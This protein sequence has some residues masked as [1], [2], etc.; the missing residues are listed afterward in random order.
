MPMRYRAKPR[1]PSPGKRFARRG[2]ARNIDARWPDREDDDEKPPSTA[3][4]A[5]DRS[6]RRNLRRAGNDEVE[7]G[8]G[9]DTVTGED[10]S[11]RID[12]D[13][14]YDAIYTGIGDNRVFGGQGTDLVVGGPGNDYARG[15]DGP[16]SL[17]GLEGNDD[18]DGEDRR[19]RHERRRLQ[20][21]PRP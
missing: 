13:K 17:F 21:L 10:G 1:S 9:F 14:G 19:A 12:G 6:G 2:A 3:I 4:E 18:L 5:A 11:D 15:A 7:A 20:R 8:D 16:D